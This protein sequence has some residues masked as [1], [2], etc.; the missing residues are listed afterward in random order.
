M[1]TLIVD[2]KAESVRLSASKLMT[3]NHTIPSKLIDLLI[4]TQD[5]E[6]KAK[7]IL[8]ISHEKIPILYISKDNR[9]MALTLPLMSK[10]SDL[11]VQ[12]YEALHNRVYFAREFLEKKFTTHQQELEHFDVTLDISQELGALQRADSV[13]SLMGV[14]GSF[15]RRYFKHYFA[16]FERKLTKGYRSKNPPQDPVNAILS[17]VYTICYYTLTAKLSMRGFDASISYLHTPF[18]DHFALSSDIMETQRAAIN[19]FV[20]KLFLNNYL[21]IEDFTF[22]GGVYLKNEARRNLWTHLKPFMDRLNKESNKSI[23]KLKSDISF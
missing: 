20:A 2:K 22:K 6:I 14:E 17:Y 21:N 1:K 4:V 13:D 11:K 9:K 3:K 7:D 16:L 19:T 5:V 23:A 15:A 18:R 12:Q 10:N 8:N